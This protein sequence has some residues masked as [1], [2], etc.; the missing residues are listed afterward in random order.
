MQNQRWVFV[1]MQ[2]CTSGFPRLFSEHL[3]DIS[4]EIASL[5]ELPIGLGDPEA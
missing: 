4:P 2:A 5:A 1:P 3:P